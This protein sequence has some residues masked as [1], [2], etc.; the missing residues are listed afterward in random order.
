[1]QTVHVYLISV[2]S[3]TL[4]FKVHRVNR[5]TVEIGW[6]IFICVDLYG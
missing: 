4:K 1:M 2:L 3:M 6:Y 5:N